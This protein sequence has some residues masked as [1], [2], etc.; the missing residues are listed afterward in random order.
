MSLHSDRKKLSFFPFGEFCVKISDISNVSCITLIVGYLLLKPR[1]QTAEIV[2]YAEH[3]CNYL[4]ISDNWFNGKKSK[5]LTSPVF[6]GYSQCICTRVIFEFLACRTI[7]GS[8]LRFKMQP[9]LYQANFQL[10]RGIN[11]EQ[12]CFDYRCISRYWL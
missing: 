8:S 7:Q 12:N 4:V 3:I 6:M 5:V 2:R 11:Y 1:Y 9:I 10:R